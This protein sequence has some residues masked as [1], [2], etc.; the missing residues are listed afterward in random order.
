MQILLII[1]ITIGVFFIFIGICVLAAYRQVKREQSELVQRT[2]TVFYMRNN[3][4]E[5]VKVEAYDFQD[6]VEASLID[7][8]D[9][10]S[11]HVYVPEYPDVQGSPVNY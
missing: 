11:I 9:I 2:F 1:L 8:K 4:P 7:E 5:K 10:T 6:A 3:F